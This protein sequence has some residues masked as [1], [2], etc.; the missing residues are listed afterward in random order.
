MSTPLDRD[1]CSG[2]PATYWCQTVRSSRLCEVSLHRTGRRAQGR[3][4]TDRGG[5]RDSGT[6]WRAGMGLRGLWGATVGPWN[7]SLPEKHA[8]SSPARADLSE[9]AVVSPLPSPRLILLHIWTADTH[10]AL[11]S[12]PPCLRLC[13]LIQEGT[14]LC[15]EC[16]HVS[17]FF[18]KSQRGDIMSPGYWEHSVFKTELETH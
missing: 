8:F 14:L 3:D 7:K 12:Y 11:F 15:R 9:R 1:L 6:N 2:W 10:W 5:H 18:I 4:V 17:L 13:L 16:L